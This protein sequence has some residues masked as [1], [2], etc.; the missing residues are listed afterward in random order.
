MG[1]FITISYMLYN[2]CPETQK[3]PGRSSNQGKGSKGYVEKNGA[4]DGNRTHAAGLG[5]QRS[6]IEL[7]PREFKKHTQILQN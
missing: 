4:G 3:G 5:S 2:V 1:N 6:T 7:H